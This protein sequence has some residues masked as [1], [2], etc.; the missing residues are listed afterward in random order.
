MKLYI[1]T[2]YCG[3]NE[4][5]D[6]TAMIHS[7]TYRSYEHFV[8][9]HLP[10]KEAHDTLFRD[11]LQHPEFDVLIKIDADTVLREKDFFQRVVDLFAQHPNIDLIEFVVYDFFERIPTMSLNCYRQGF[12]IIDKGPL[13]VDRITDIA[14]ERRMIS[15]HV[16]STHCPNPSEYQ[17]FHFGY[18]AQLKSRNATVQHTLRSYLA[19]LDRKRALALCGAMDVRRGILGISQNQSY[20][21]AAI[22][23]RSKYFG[24]MSAPKLFMRILCFYLSMG[25]LQCAGKAKRLCGRTFV[26]FMKTNP[27]SPGIA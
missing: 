4:L 12:H 13:F 1:G 19:T 26:K 8:F 16:S 2:L 6:C 27:G 10:N 22:Q 15:R 14:K 23:A 20:L 11:F 5:A 17:A 25:I 24:Q 21:N 18:H 9:R 3:E 7:Q